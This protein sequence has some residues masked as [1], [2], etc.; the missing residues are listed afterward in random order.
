MS[1]LTSALLPTLRSTPTELRMRLRYGV[2]QG[3][4]WRHFALGPERES[5]W[6]RLREMDTRIIRVFLFDREMPD[7]ATEWQ[8]LASYLEA[9]LQVRAKP[10]V[11]FARF[12]PPFDSPNAIRA[13]ADRCA[14]L[15]RR[16]IEQWG[17]DVTRDWYWCVWHQP[18]SEWGGGLDF[19]QY[20]CIYEEAAQGIL[21][22]LAPYLR[23]R[24]A[25]I[26]GPAVDGFQPFWLDWIWRFVN[27][28]DNTV[29][30]FAS[31]H[32]YGDWRERGEWGAPEDPAIFQ[33]LLMSRTRE[34]ESRAR[35]V[36]RLLRGRGIL[37]VCGEL[38][39]HAHYEPRVSRPF[40]QTLFG[41]AYYVSSLLHLMRGGADVELLRNG[42]DHTGRYGAID[43][44]GAPTPLFHAKRLC[45][46]HIRYGDSISFPSDPN[47]SLEMVLARSR[48][49]RSSLLLVHLDDALR[50]FELP[51]VPGFLLLKMD[52]STGDRIAESTFRGAVTFHGYGVAV[53]TN[54]SNENQ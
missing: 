28:I 41:A 54:L 4:S 13:F 35:T 33:A 21:R 42:T 43:H 26:G 12:P 40:N 24:K 32:R 16:S 51:E 22:W 52:G 19:E 20:R 5:I 53:V 31:W 44:T 37:N 3:E 48:Q 49:G 17:G 47:R 23:G 27:E 30:G 7:P 9:V 36:S 18:N 50:T 10:M 46:R 39:A 1:T 2:N 25:L 14:A 45:A 6:A 38:N 15:V 8:L 11:T 29:I 34:Y